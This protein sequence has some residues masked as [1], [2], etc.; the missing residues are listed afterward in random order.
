L[1]KHDLIGINIFVQAVRG[2]WTAPSTRF[3]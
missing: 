3:P 2:A 1:S